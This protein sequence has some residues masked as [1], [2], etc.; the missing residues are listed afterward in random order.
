MAVRSIAA[1]GMALALTACCNGEKCPFIDLKSTACSAASPYP[2]GTDLAAFVE[3][4]LETLPESRNGPS[5]A[6]ALAQHE[7]EAIALTNQDA[8]L[9]T[10]GRALA[11][12]W[13][14]HTRL[15]VEGFGGEAVVTQPMVDDFAAY[16]DR[17]QQI[18]SPA[19]AAAIAAERAAVPPLA[20][21][22]G[23]NMDAFRA[24]V[25]PLDQV[26][27]DDYE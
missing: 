20:S 1:A 19:L 8:E 7:T 4:Y 17:M 25:L 27:A 5:I 15:F 21:L 13:D 24:A 16:L 6:V 10:R 26:F 22:A 9:C 3:V 11:A 18:G 23:R 12:Q 14:D 2:A